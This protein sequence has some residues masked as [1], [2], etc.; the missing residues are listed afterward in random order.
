MTRPI[1][2]RARRSALDAL[3]LDARRLRALLRLV[4]PER[5]DGAEL[6]VRATAF[7]CE[8]L[9][10]ADS[11]DQGEGLPMRRVKRGTG[12]RRR[13]KGRARPSAGEG[14]GGDATGAGTPNDRLDDLW[15]AG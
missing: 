4:D 5:H 10:L 3:G 1:S 2:D 13:G 6:A 15:A 14:R 11:E 8:L 9:A 12:A 7:F